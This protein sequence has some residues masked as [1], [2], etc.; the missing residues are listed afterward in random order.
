M[1]LDRDDR[2]TL[3]STTLPSAQP[4]LL[5]QHTVSKTLIGAVNFLFPE[6]VDA[7]TRPGCV[8]PTLAGGKTRGDHQNNKR[9][10]DYK[11]R[12]EQDKKTTR[13]EDKKTRRQQDNKTTRQDDNKTRRQPD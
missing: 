8:E 11:K 13:L 9:Q 5:N 4:L 1:P 3:T 6:N 12:K 10:E 7:I 2:L